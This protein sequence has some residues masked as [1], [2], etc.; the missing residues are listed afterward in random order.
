MCVNQTWIRIKNGRKMLVKCGHCPACQQEKALQ[1]TNRIRANFP[2]DSKSDI[3][4]VFTTLTY[5]N[6]CVPYIRTDDWFY[7]GCGDSVYVPVY[8]DSMVRW[9]RCSKN[10]HMRRRVIAGRVEIAVPLVDLK[11]FKAAVETAHP[12]DGKPL[13]GRMVYLRGQSDCKVGVIHF[14]DAQNF[15]KNLRQTLIRN[16]HYENSFSFFCCA[17]FGPTTCRP[18]FHFLFFIPSAHYSM[19]KCAVAKTWSY[20]DYKATY[21]STTI[22]RNA[23]AYVSSYVNCDSS[24]PLVFRES[25]FSPKHSY[26]QGFGTALRAYKIE[27]IIKAY[28]RGDLRTD[29]SRVRQ[30]ALVTDT[31]LL[32]KYVIS[33]YFPKFLGYSR[34]TSDEIRDVYARPEHIWRYADKILNGVRLIPHGWYSPLNRAKREAFYDKVY[35]PEYKFARCFLMS[36]NETA[37]RWVRRHHPDVEPHHFAEQRI[38]AIQTCLQHKLDYALSRGIDKADYVDTA[39]G[40]WTLRASQVLR[41]MYEEIDDVSNYMQLYDNIK[42]FYSGDVGSD[43]L[44]DIM[45]NLSNDYA[46]E[47]NPNHFIRN[48]QRHAIMEAAYHSYSKDKKVRNFVYSR[49]TNM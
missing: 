7:A 14:P 35:Q 11:M 9:V 23:A 8:R 40:I 21:N 45:F 47:V 49:T 31:I 6:E 22:A 42:D 3:I 15:I 18:H 33:R 17:E 32:P 25:S 30:G 13:D 44:D 12:Y 24:V 26:S 10:Y 36:D 1:R 38:S 20:D 27:E 37:V 34:L 2:D 48:K 28:R 29:V 46:Y 4:A 43:S 41:Y 5:R 39:V 16:Y 19:F